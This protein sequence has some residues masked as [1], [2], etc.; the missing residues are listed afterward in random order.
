MTSTQHTPTISGPWTFNADH[1]PVSNGMYRADTLHIVERGTLVA[2]VTVWPGKGADAVAIAHLMAAA[3]D[4]LAAIEALDAC[5][6]IAPH[7]CASPEGTRAMAMA[8]AAMA[9]ARGAA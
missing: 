1:P 5:G 4:M 3:P 8:R 2:A 6:Y 9:K 7:S